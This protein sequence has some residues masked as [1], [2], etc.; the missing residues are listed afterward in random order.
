MGSEDELAAVLAHEVCCV[1]QACVRMCVRGVPACCMCGRVWNAG[2]VS[3]CTPAIPAA[4]PARTAPGCT[5]VGHV[6]AR[7][8]AERISQ[9]NMTGLVNMLLRALLG[10]SIPGSLVV[11][12]MFL[13]Y[14]RWGL[15]S[16]RTGAMLRLLTT[17]LQLCTASAHRRWLARSLLPLPLLMQRNALAELQSTRQTRLACA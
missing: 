6:L 5:Q 4:L 3:S 1:C 10:I 17:R 8:H 15:C 2:Q 11:L 7:H 12:G 14:S 9:L 13:P 16:P